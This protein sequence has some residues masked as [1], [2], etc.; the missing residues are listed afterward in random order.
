[1]TKIIG[2]D[3]GKKGAICL[4]EKTEQSVTCH[5]MPDTTQG[6]HDILSGFP[7]VSFA[8]VEK[9]FYPH[10]IGVTNATK[11]AEAYGTLKGALQWLSIPVRE[12]RPL[13]W[14]RSLNLS[15]SK[16]ASREMASMLFP[17]HSAQWARAKDDG[18]AEA[19]LI[20]WY[21]LRWAS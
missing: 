10:H 21:G 8:V 12:V 14:K 9:P 4:F 6:L 17:D 7:V 19:A 16:S 13:D 11:I 20:A 5:D 1:M 15:S 18:R 2:I 3:P